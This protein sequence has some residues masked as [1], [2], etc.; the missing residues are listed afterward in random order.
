[1]NME[2]IILEMLARI[3]DLEEKVD[4]L[5]A[6]QNATDSIKTGT[7]DIK[8][9]I[10]QLKQNSKQ[11]GDKFLILKANEIHN[12]LNLKSR[13]PAVCS[14][15]RQCMNKADIVLHETPSGFSST[16]EV[17]YMT[18]N[19]D[20]KLLWEKLKDYQ[21]QDFYTAIDNKLFRFKF[22]NQNEIAITTTVSSVIHIED[23]EKVVEIMPVKGPGEIKKQF[24]EMMVSSYVYA[25]LLD[26]RFKEV[27]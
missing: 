16:F 8:N 27:L 10:F 9:Y 6:N 12:N 23:F 25:L 14:A 2:K 3:K 15:M 1:M 4:K 19:R 21:N 18:D 7:A 11:N 20:V 13:M 17:K 24:P 22:V 26:E 5:T